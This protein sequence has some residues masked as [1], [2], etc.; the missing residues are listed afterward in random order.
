MTPLTTLLHSSLDD[1]LGVELSRLREQQLERILRPTG[2]RRGAIVETEHGPAVDFS[3]N[4]YLGLSGHPAVRDAAVQALSGYGL[5]ATASRLVRG[6][7]DLHTELERRLAAWLGVAGAL[8]FSSGYL[9]NIGALRVL[10]APGTL[11]IDT[12]A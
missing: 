3:S 4:D 6:T 1:A 8:V 2:H 10:A 12:G 9:A 7:T 5:G 11:V